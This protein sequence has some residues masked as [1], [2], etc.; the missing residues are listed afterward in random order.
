MFIF[1]ISYIIYDTTIKYNH[2]NIKRA[3][4]FHCNLKMHLYNLCRYIYF[5]KKI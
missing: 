3:N 2:N 5:I 1:I 4:N